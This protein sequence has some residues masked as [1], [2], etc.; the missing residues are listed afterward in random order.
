V[1]TK[2][3]KIGSHFNWKNI[4]KNFSGF[5]YGKIKWMSFIFLLIIA[6]YS[7]YLWYVFIFRAEWNETKKQEY[8]K[9]K[10]AGVIINKN[11][12]LD[13]VNEYQ[14]RGDEY[15]KKIEPGQD[16]FRLKQ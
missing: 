13:V 6:G 10:D 4:S 5:I 1:D 9:S 8:I 16:I 14:R 12:F 7:S 3:E 15:Q 2:I 11:R